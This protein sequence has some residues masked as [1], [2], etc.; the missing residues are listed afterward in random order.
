MMQEINNKGEQC[1]TEP[2]FLSMRNWF[3]EY[4]SRVK[5]T[6]FNCTERGLVIKGI[7]NRSLNEFTFDKE[8]PE[9]NFEP[10]ETNDINSALLGELEKA[11][12]FISATHSVTP[13]IQKY[14]AWPLIEEFVQSDIYLEEIRSETRIR[15]GMNAKESTSAFQ[16]NRLDIILNNIDKLVNLLK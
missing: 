6:A 7:S 11:K 2:S 12:E 16:K 9:V 15:Q 14:K 3:E 1:S 13:E 8:I 4:V 5:P 10:V